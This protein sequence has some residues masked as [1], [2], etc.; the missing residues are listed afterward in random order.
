MPKVTEADRTCQSC[1]KTGRICRYR[2]V[3]RQISRRFG[4]RRVEL[5]GKNAIAKSIRWEFFQNDQECSKRH[6]TVRA[7]SIIGQLAECGITSGG[8]ND[9]PFYNFDPWHSP[10]SRPGPSVCPSASPHQT[11][12]V[13]VACRVSKSPQ[14]ETT[15]RLASSARS[16][17]IGA[18]HFL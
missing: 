15:R 12:G 7:V 14:T 11:T 4:G 1:S 2:L 17:S 13:P 18:L 10:R 16:I 9:F 6:C 5:E 3:F 8:P